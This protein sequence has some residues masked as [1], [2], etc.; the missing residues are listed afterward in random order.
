MNIPGGESSLAILRVDGQTFFFSGSEVK[1]NRRTVVLFI[2]NHGLSWAES[3]ARGH[4]GLYRSQKGECSDYTE[5]HESC[6]VDS[7]WLAGMIETIGWLSG[8]KR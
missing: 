6:V 5:H 2:G 8:R 3:N 1:R 4:T 7:K